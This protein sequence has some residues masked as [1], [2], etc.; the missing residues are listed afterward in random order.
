MK[1]PMSAPAIPQQRTNNESV[2]CLTFKALVSSSI[3]NGVYASISEYPLSDARS[4]AA[5]IFSGASNSAMIPNIGGRFISFS[6]DRVHRAPERN[7]KSQTPN[8]K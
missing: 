1:N 6:Y 5:R 4:A 2:V 8:Y 7:P 3:G